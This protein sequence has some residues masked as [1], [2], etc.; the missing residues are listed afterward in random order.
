MDATAAAGVASDGTPASAALAAYAAARAAGSFGL[1]ASAAF[2]AYAAACG[3][4]LTSGIAIPM[5]K[6]SAKA[7]TRDDGSAA[8]GVLS[9]SSPIGFASCSA[10]RAIASLD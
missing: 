6:A 10:A 5:D 9:G 3:L 7:P 2:A 4:T 8:S 1:A